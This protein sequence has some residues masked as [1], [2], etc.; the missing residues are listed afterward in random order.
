MIKA[1]PKT[2]NKLVPKI[3]RNAITTELLKYNNK[4]YE[5]QGCH[6]DKRKFKCI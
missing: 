5:Q 6:N 4:L 1:Q 2:L 3:Y